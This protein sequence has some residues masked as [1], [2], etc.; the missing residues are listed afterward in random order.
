MDRL[1]RCDFCGSDQGVHWYPSDAPGVEY[2]A[3]A[4]CVALI[5]NQDWRAFLDRIISAFVAAQIVPD[6]EQIAFRFE[7]E[8]AIVQPLEVET[9]VSRTFGS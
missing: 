8:C 5:R 2:Y 3:C 7:L 4:V 6:G 1:V 9:V